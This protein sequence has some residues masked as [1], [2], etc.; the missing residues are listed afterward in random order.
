M[1]EPL[2]VDIWRKI[3]GLLSKSPGLTVS[4]ISEQLNVKIT[5]LEPYLLSMEENQEIL[6]VVDNSVRRY[7]LAQGGPLF[8]QD[9]RTEDTRLQIYITISKNPGLHLSKI[10]EILHMSPPLAKYHLEALEK[11]DFIISTKDEK[12][13]YKRYYLKDSGV[14]T[15]EKQIMAL[16]RQEQLLKIVLLLYR[17]TRLQ[18]GALVERLTISPATLSYHLNKLVENGVI[19]CSS[20][21]AEKGY[22]LKNEKQVIWLVR[23]YKLHRI[24]DGFNELW[25]DLSLSGE[26]EKVSE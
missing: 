2:E 9:R 23:K 24:F 1:S 5:M 20:F 13:Y 21:G 16:L 10:A 11:E 4:M 19:E 26:K 8:P 14:G 3:I 7:S 15:E 17:H 25:K 6:S 22:C 18:H 12:G